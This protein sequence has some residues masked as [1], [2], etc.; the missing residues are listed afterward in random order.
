M[1]LYTMTRPSMPLARACAPSALPSA[2]SA[3]VAWP[4]AEQVP[5]AM[6]PVARV[7][8]VQA[9]AELALTEQLIDGTTGTAGTTNGF[10]GIDVATKRFALGGSGAPPRGRPV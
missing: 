2:V 3:L 5:T 1:E 6:A 8:Q 7:H 10:N 4:A 9:Q